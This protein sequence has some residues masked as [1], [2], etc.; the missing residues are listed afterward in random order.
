MLT[1]PESTRRALAAL[2]LAGVS[3]VGM[4]KARR[5]EMQHCNVQGPKES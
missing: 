3:C 1:A 2:G 5:T 4:G